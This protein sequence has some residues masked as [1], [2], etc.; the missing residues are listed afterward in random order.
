[1]HQGSSGYS[2]DPRYYQ[3]QQLIYNQMVPSVHHS[4]L[5]SQSN[6]VDQEEI[7]ALVS[8]G[9][10]VEQAMAVCETSRSASNDSVCRLFSS[11]Y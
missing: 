5:P 8:K 9:Y 3:Q 2:I 10:T 1:M 7:D 4:P 11:L 6:T